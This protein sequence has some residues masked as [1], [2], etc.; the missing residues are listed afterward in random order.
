MMTTQCP[1]PERSKEYGPD[2][3]IVVRGGGGL[4]LGP[5]EIESKEGDL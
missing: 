4:S 3:A 5:L 1:W 2:W